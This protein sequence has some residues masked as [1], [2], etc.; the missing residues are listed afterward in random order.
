[1]VAAL[2]VVAGCAAAP[3]GDAPETIVFLNP[4]A[5]AYD[6][7]VAEF[8]ARNPDIRVEQQSVP[9][10][11][12]VS[13]TQA[14]LASGD[15]SVDVVS[16]DPPRLAGMVTQGFLTDESASADLLESTSSQVGINSVTV[17]DRP[18]AYPLWTSDA[19][20]F[21]NRDALTRAGVP[22]PGPSDADRL[23]WDQVLDGART[24][25]EADT[26]RYGFGID[27][28]DRYYALQPIL[29]SM[30]AGPG[31]E[32]PDSL[33]AAV[34]TPEW[35]RFGAWYR[36]L[37][38]DGLAP[39]GVDPGQ[40]ADLFAS[41]G[42]GFYL[43]G[44]SSITKI[45]ESDLAGNWGIAPAPY[46]AGGPVVT[47]TD[48][49]GVGISAYSEK[50]DAARRFAQFMTLDP[51]GVSAASRTMNLPP[52]ATA[53][54]PAYLDHLAEVAPAETAGIGD[55]LEIDL[56]RHARHR[57]TSVGYV[58]FETTLNRAFT[59]LRNGGDVDSVLATAQDTLVRQLDRQR[60]LAGD[61]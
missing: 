57:P 21:Y 38:T 8:E 18:W 26:A 33:T 32:G 48:S 52:V 9:F 42:L 54:M 37:Y 27:Q 28:V 10:D 58:Q 23:T 25:A 55:L 44:A 12:M 51:E 59:D 47:P 46:V 39:R 6:D 50:Q 49:W 43:S 20:L 40:M 7:V 35:K 3:A 1:M 16:V 17:D 14:R 2:A 13:Q 19:F 22:I 30:G 56:E 45:A 5:G 11:Q 36:D 61:H 53:A 41:G 60:E 29:E 15:T 24:V 31:L 34:D 4:H